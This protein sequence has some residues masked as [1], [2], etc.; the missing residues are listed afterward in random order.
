MEKRLY[1]EMLENLDRLVRSHAIQGRRIYLFG[2][3]SAAE[4][5]ADVLLDRGF[6]VAAFLDNNAAK[7]VNLNRAI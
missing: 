2:H 5:L 7:Q 1:E 3:C 6:D 4:E